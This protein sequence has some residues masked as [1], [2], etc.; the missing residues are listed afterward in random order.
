MSLNLFSNSAK[1]NVNDRNKGPEKIS[2]FTDW[3]SQLDISK[4]QED[5]LDHAI[6]KLKFNRNVMSMAGRSPN[7]PGEVHIEV[8]IF[9]PLYIFPAAFT[10]IVKYSLAVNQVRV[11]LK[12]VNA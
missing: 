11:N 5:N 9:I 2:V 1:T 3:R 10:V 4:H 8:D 7:T 6:D 12:C